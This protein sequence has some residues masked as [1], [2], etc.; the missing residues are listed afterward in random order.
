MMDM[1]I[2][3]GNPRPGDVRSRVV[4][5]ASYVRMYEYTSMYIRR[6]NKEV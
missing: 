3:G 1:G 4:I 6:S 5:K 2:D